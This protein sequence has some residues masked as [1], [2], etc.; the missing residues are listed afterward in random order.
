MTQQVRPCS[1]HFA[2]VFPFTSKLSESIDRKGTWV[3]N[4]LTNHPIYYTI[5]LKTWEEHFTGSDSDFIN[6]LKNE[7]NN[8]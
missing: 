6:A 1:T 4:G 3:Q 8:W 2:A 5:R 7:N